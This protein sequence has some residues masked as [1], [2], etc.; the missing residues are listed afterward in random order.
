MLDR[1]HEFIDGEIVSKDCNDGDSCTNDYCDP[2][3]GECQ[4]IPIPGC[5]VDNSDPT[6]IQYPRGGTP[7]A[8]EIPYQFSPASSPESKDTLAIDYDV[9]QSSLVS[10]LIYD[11]NGNLIRTLVNQAIRNPGNHVDVWDGRNNSGELAS[12]GTYQFIINGVNSQNPLDTWQSTGDIVIDNFPPTAK[13]DFI[14]SD[15]PEYGHYTI[16][17]TA[18]DEHFEK[19]FIECFNEYTHV[20]LEL[21]ELPAVKGILGAFDSIYYKGGSY[22]VRLTVIDL[23]GNSAT[24]EMPLIIDRTTNGLKVHINSTAQNVNLGSEGYIP[25]SDDPDVWIDDGLPSG[26]TEMESWEWDTDV[27]YSGGQSHTDSARVGTHGHYFIHADD[28]LDLTSVDNIIQY[29]YLDP[30]N[31]PS[32][33]MLQ[34]YTEDGNG[35]H[36][37]LWGGN[38]VPTGGNWGSASL[39]YMGHM[40]ETGK[41]IRLKIPASAVGLS[42][43]KVKGVAFVTYGG[44]AYWDKTTKSSDYNETQEDSWVLASQVFSEPG[45]DTIINYSTSQDANISLTIY[46]EDNNLVKTLLDEFITEGYHEIVWD[47]TDDTEGYHEI[48]W[49]GTDDN[50]GQTPDGKYYFQFSSY[51]GPVDSNAY[52]LLLGDWSSETVGANT[53]VTDSSGNRYEIDFVNHV[54]NKYDSLDVLLFSITADNVGVNSFDPVAL[55]LDINNNLFIVDNTLSKIFKL[56]PDGYYLNEMPYPSGLPWADQSIGLDQ[57]NAVFLDDNGDMLVANQDGGEILKLGTGRGIV[58]I[59]NIT[60]EIRVPYE[61]CLVYAFIPIIGTASARDFQ[62]YSVDYGYGENPTEWTTIITSYTEVFDDY[63]PIPDSRT[64]YGN[65]ATWHVTEQA[66]DRTGGLPMGTHTIR[67]R[68][69][70]Q[71]GNYGEDTARAHVARVIGRWGGTVLSDDGLVAFDIPNGGIADDN[72]LF[73]ISPVDVAEAPPIDDPDLTLTGK[74]YEVRPAGYEF[75][76]S[77]TLKM[78]YTDEQLGGIDENTLKIYRWSPIIQCWIYVFADLDTANNVLTTT[79]SSFNDYEVYYAII[80]DPPPA[81]VIYQPAS[82]TNL[83]KITVFGKATPSVSVEIFLDGV[84]QGTTQ[85]DENSGNFI[86]TGVQLNVG[87]NYLTALAADPVGNTSPLSN[88]VLVQVVLAQPTEVVSVGFKTSD[89]LADFT[90]DIAIGESLYIELVGTDADPGSVD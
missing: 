36:R 65:M 23:S 38:Y 49:D 69:Y 4:N 20:Y 52:A 14:K 77:C 43:K 25:T 70:D 21:K 66:Y 59:T 13:I 11:S 61:D 85:A 63:K 51:D 84:S 32:E 10:I 89:F 28:T 34:F 7:L 56:N 53:S 2:A 37:A 19:Y 72:D 3:T 87:D 45:T 64:I 15:T 78:Y 39:Y 17:G 55:D 81:P 44:K 83:K 31:P 50:N 22:T 46:D 48:V 90:N 30:S 57:P 58:D 62:K 42:G 68:V 18:V 6:Y 27:K 29:V 79:L 5:D 8:N 26:S 71:E 74:I 76:K 24:D 60:A 12:D 35:E 47:G 54:V 40:P 67:L 86:K 75:T 33:I 73:S 82:P 16:I 1:C 41:W 9:A 88:P 80:A